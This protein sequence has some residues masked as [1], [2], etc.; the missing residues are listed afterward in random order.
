LV[1][2]AADNVDYEYHIMR[3]VLAVSRSVCLG[4]ESLIFLNE[5]NVLLTDAVGWDRLHCYLEGHPHLSLPRG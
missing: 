2:R 4:R 1:E 3:R 5:T